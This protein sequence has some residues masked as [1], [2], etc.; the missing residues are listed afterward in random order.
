MKTIYDYW[1]N[2]DTF[3]NCKFLLYNMKIA[4]FQTGE[5]V[6]DFALN[7]KIFFNNKK[8]QL[9]TKFNCFSTNKAQLTSTSEVSVSQSINDSS[10][11]TVA[12][13]GGITSFNGVF[14]LIRRNLHYLTLSF[15][16]SIKNNESETSVP[17][18]TNLNY[19]FS[20]HSFASFGIENYDHTK[21]KLPSLL[22]FSLLK[23]VIYKGIKFYGGVLSKYSLKDKSVPY[24]KIVSSAMT[25]SY[26]GLLGVEF[27]ENKKLLNVK[28][29][30][31]YKDVVIG[32]E[33]IMNLPSLSRVL[34]SYYMTY[35]INPTTVVKSKW[36]PVTNCVILSLAQTFRQML[37]V[38]VSGKFVYASP[39][40]EDKTKVDYQFPKAKL[41]VSLELF[42][43]SI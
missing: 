38:S 7:S 36:N 43:N 1:E 32:A 27:K 16:S 8:S 12:Q 18:T 39:K 24:T 33:R 11:V 20:D 15:N 30:T 19:H 4:K 31:K 2:Q 26:G 10:K 17:I 9:N 40:A 14:G 29:F 34:E 41:G 42:D 5:G 3:F 21:E 6:N 35:E 23:G 22:T 13:K 25:P 28:S 37:K